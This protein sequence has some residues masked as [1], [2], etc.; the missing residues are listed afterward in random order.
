MVQAWWAA[1]LVVP[2]VMIKSALTGKGRSKTRVEE[3]VEPRYSFSKAV[4]NL[5]LLSS[6]SG[7]ML[8]LVSILFHEIV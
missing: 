1:G 5:R 4:P 3:S 7:R 6:K 2:A 8:K